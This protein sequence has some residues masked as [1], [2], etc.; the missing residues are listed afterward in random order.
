MEF[1]HPPTSAKSIPEKHRDRCAERN[2]LPKFREGEKEV[3]LWSFA[4]KAG[5]KTPL[6]EQTID[7]VSPNR[8]IQDG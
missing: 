4:P 3:F 5:A 1:T 7:F 2:S 6:A 8:Q